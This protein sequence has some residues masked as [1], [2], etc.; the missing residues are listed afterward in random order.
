MGARI[1]RQSQHAY[2]YTRIKLATR[3]TTTMHDMIT[4]RVCRK[5][6][7]MNCVGAS[8]NDC[9]R[10]T[11]HFAAKRRIDIRMISAYIVLVARYA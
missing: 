3:P 11:C 8:Y 7:I 2:T 10:A 6:V 4:C 9:R 1:R 5:G